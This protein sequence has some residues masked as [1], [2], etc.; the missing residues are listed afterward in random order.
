[1]LE[2]LDHLVVGGYGDDHYREVFG[3]IV[4]QLCE[5]HTTICKPGLKLVKTVKQ[6]M[7]RL[8]QYRT[9]MNSHDY[10]LDTRMSC[11]VN[12]LVSEFNSFMLRVLS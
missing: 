5:K 6:L 12:L 11:T 2:K 4:G 3:Q 7:E 9:I 8:L 10:S 1:M